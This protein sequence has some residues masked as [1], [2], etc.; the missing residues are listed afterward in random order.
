[1]KRLGAAFP[2]RTR[3]LPV[4]ARVDG[5][6]LD[7]LQ[8]IIR[9]L[10]PKALAAFFCFLQQ[11]ANTVKHGNATAIESPKKKKNKKK[12]QT[13]LDTAA[14]IGVGVAWCALALL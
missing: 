7:Y 3:H 2:A 14:A 4:D 5:R 12:K 9:R 1:M 10:E 13:N 11:H 8:E 6:V